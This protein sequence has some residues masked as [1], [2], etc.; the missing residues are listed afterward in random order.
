[1]APD[2]PYTGLF[3]QLKPAH[4]A[5]GAI[6]LDV[7]ID[8][9]L[10][11]AEQLLDDF[12]A[13]LNDGVGVDPMV[14]ER[15]RLPW[16]HA[17][18]WTGFS[19]GDPTGRFKAKSA[20]LRTGFPDSHLA[21]LY[22]GMT[23][24]DYQYPFAM[25]MITSFGGKINA[26]PRTATAVPAPDSILKLHYIVFWA[27]PADDARHVGWIRDLYRDVYAETGGVPVPNA[28]TDGCFV[29]YAD[30]DLSDP[31]QNTSGVPWYSLYY[32]EN[33]PRLQ[34]V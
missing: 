8:A 16:L 26:V 24:T 22:R 12:L 1:S 9:T 6:T 18:Q 2:S 33:Y 11:R 31:A 15:I 30:A 14:L 7:Q 27:D 29:N 20:Y 17:A 32:E 19:G 34:R 5:S 28:V 10:P 25:L 23:R 21:A 13:S 3:S 4:Q